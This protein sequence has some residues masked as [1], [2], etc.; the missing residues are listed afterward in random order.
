MDSVNSDLYRTFRSAKFVK[1]CCRQIL[2]I[3]SKRVEIIQQLLSVTYTVLPLC[4][5]EKRSLF[6]FIG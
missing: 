3:Q 4:Y 6:F 2:Q 1:H 5:Y